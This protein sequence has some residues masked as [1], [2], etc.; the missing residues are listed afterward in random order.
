VLTGKYRS[1]PAAGRAAGTL[2]DPRVARAAA[3]A[4]ELAGLAGRLGV[5][6]ATLALA[7]PLASPAVTSVLFGATSAE[8]VGANCAAVGLRDRL[9][10][11]DIAALRRIGLS[12]EEPR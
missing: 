6:A 12:A 8:Q 4:D 2:T 1:D 5:P 7:S 11:Q 10:R 3:A 9:G